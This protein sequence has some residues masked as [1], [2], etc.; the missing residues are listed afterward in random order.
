[1][2]EKKIESKLKKLNRIQG[3]INDLK[4]EEETAKETVKIA[5]E[6][7]EQ[8]QDEITHHETIITNI[9]AEIE[10]LQKE[11]MSEAEKMRLMGIP[12]LF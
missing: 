12:E 2:N 11:Q 3:D 5:Q 8:I 1:M 9:L 4:E 6:E 7:L 10:T